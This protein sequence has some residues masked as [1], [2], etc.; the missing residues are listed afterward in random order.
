MEPRDILQGVRVLIVDDHPLNIFALE[1]AL[2]SVLDIEILSAQS[3][4]EA[5]EL[6][7]SDD[8][9]VDVVL[10]DMMMPIMSGYEATQR[11]RENEKQGGTALIIIA[12]TARAMKEDREKCFSAGVS[13]Y[14]SKPVNIFTLIEVMAKHYGN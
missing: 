10:M 9:G 6:L 13:D 8:H 11:I 7:S 1:S 12:V 3:G 14:V 5:L 4:S 2:K